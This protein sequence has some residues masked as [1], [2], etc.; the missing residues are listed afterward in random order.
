MDT[1]VKDY[2]RDYSTSDYFLFLDPKMKDHAE[3]ILSY[4]CDETGNEPSVVT[5]ENA[6]RNVAHLNV[7]VEVKRG[8]PALVREFY[9]YLHSSGKVPRAESWIPEID[10]CQLEYL[11]GFRDDGSVRGITHVKKYSDVGRND[12]CPCGSGKKFKKCCMSLIN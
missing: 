1:S 5:I 6:F 7:N 10:V 4:W 11:R 3:S 12:P 9:T 8:I 2:I